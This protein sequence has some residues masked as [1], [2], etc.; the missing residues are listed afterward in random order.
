MA[1]ALVPPNQYRNN[2]EEN[3]NKDE[4]TTDTNSIH[5]PNSNKTIQQAGSQ[6]NKNKRQTTQTRWKSTPEHHFWDT[7][8]GSV[9]NKSE[10][11]LRLS[12]P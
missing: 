3:P 2:N 10:L 7:P 12:Q 6:Q 4:S 9:N 8:S 1:A 5:E 11:T